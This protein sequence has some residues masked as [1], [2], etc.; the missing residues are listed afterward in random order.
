MNNEMVYDPI[1]D[2]EGKQVHTTPYLV[3]HSKLLTPLPRNRTNLE[4]RKD[5]GN[6]LVRPP[7]TT[8]MAID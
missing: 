3:V 7:P 4:P 5:E 1:V 2:S 8:N 6:K